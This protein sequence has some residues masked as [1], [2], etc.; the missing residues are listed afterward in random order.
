MNLGEDGVKVDAVRQGGA[1][2]DVND[3][4]KLMGDCRQILLPNRLGEFAH[5]LVEQA[6]ADG[7][8]PVRRYLGH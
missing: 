3:V 4:G 6:L 1:E 2:G 8:D 5:L 7:G